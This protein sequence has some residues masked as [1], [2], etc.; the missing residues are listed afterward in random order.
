MRKSS[1]MKIKIEVSNLGLA[2]G[3]HFSTLIKRSD[4][5][6]LL[7]FSPPI[8]FIDYNVIGGSVFF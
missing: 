5:P 1:F 4:L 3:V 7:H 8:S 2:G 6:T